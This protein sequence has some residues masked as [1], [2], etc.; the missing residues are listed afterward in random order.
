MRNSFK[1]LDS[2]SSQDRTEW[3]ELWSSW[4]SREVQAHPAYSELFAKDCEQVLAAIFTSAGGHNIIYPFLLRTIDGTSGSVSLKDISTPYGYGG[5]VTWGAR[6][7]KAESDFFW[8][9]FET[10]A[11]AE[12]V[13]SE[14]IRYGLFNVEAIPYLGEQ[15]TRQ[16]NFIVDLQSSEDL[17]WQSFEAKV[18]RNVN[19][20]KREE[21]QVEFSSSSDGLEIFHPIY[22]ATMD[23]HNAGSE[24]CFSTE[25][26]DVIHRELPKQFAYFHAFSNGRPVSTELVLISEDTVYFF[27]GGTLL[28][29]FPM[30]TNELLKFEIM[31]WAKQNGKKRYVL[32]GGLTPH[33]GLERYKRS[34]APKGIQ[35]FVTGQRIFDR[36]AYASLVAAKHGINSPNTTF[37]PAYRE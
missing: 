1:I 8:S 27:L 17:L 28:E 25:F 23:R 36:K 18:R 3:I 16:Q 35:D 32:G 29:G 9:Q 20:A 6:V 7:S 31:K 26:F 33:D 24:Y 19:K 11:M 4:P 34:F 37:F 22:Q 12:N 5:P 2:S 15:I 14:F 13:V 30:R 10:W 21:V